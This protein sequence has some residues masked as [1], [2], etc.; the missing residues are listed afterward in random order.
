MQ[1]DGGPGAGGAGAPIG[2]SFTGTA[3]ALELVGDHCYAYSGALTVTDTDSHKL[4]SFTSGNYYSVVDFTF[5]RRSWEDDDIAYYVE[6]NGT[7][8]VAW[9]GRQ[10]EPN[11]ANMPIPL[12]IPPYTEIEAYV[13]KQQH[14]NLSIVGINIT[15]RIYRG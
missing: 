10:S 2:G 11:G 15:G 13:D 9:I 5:W 14:A 4:L 12:V 1:R 7:Q 8:V 3:E 6:M